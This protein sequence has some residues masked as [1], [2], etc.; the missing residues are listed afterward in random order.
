MMSTR[1]N[2]LIAGSGVCAGMLAAGAAAQ[3]GGWQPSAAALALPGR[4]LWSSAESSDSVPLDVAIDTKDG[5]RD[6]GA[7][8]G[9][10]VTVLSFWATWCAPCL[11][12]KP[13]LDDLAGRLAAASVAVTVIS[14]MSGSINGPPDF[15]TADAAHKRL[16]LSHLQPLVDP[17]DVW[18]SPFTPFMNATGRRPTP[19]ALPGMGRRRGALN[20]QLPR[21]LLLAPNGRELGRINAAIAANADTN[22]WR[23]PQTF[24]F[25]R[26]LAG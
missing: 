10:K 2:V 21:S 4:R 24:S 7:L 26:A 18:Q 23:D 11:A 3:P 5:L 13:H 17:A 6:L 22:V 8:T 20:L 16:K 15:Q 19:P 14:L 1:R 12:E 9:G 25:L